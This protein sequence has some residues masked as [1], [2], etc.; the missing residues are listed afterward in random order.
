MTPV[1]ITV[2]GSHTVRVA[3]EQ[4]TVYAELAADGPEPQP[5]FDAVAAALDGVRRSLESRLQ[6][7]GPVTRF[8]VEQVRRASHRPYNPEGRQLPLVHTASVS[9]S[10]T[11]TD[12]DDLAGWVS[13][14]AGVPGLAVGHID[15]ALSEATRPQV[16]RSTRQEAV[17]DAK[18]RAQDY[19]DALDLGP[20]S[21]RS[22][23]DP[24]TG[25]PPMP[26]VMMARA[27]SDPGGPPE[28]SLRPDEVEIQAQVE[29]T[30][31]VGADG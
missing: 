29:A 30:F 8:V 23:S 9:I 14:S 7:D 18:R 4:A 19:A 26:K 28:I 6:E 22:I 27:M 31:T 11:F 17:R 10:A 2:R 12:F 1:E 21:V 5:V 24:G 25:G 16:E 3:P 13:L 20:V 15:W